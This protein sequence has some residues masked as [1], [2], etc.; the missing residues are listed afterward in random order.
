MIARL[1]CDAI[2]KQTL[3]VIHTKPSPNLEC[4]HLGCNADTSDL[5]PLIHK[6][7]HSC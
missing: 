6:F 3:H 2:N 4:K 1:V 5:E 7:R